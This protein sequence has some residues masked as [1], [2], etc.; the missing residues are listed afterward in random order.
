MLVRCGYSSFAPESISSP[1]KNCFFF[2]FVF[3]C[4]QI[5]KDFLI[6]AISDQKLTG[7]SVSYFWSSDRSAIHKMLALVMQ[8]RRNPRF[9]RLI[10]TKNE[11]RLWNLLASLIKTPK[12]WQYFCFLYR[13]PFRETRGAF[14]GTWGNWNI[15]DLIE[16][17][18]SLDA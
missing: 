5:T 11:T 3:V 7:E 18:V 2:S 14:D 1:G 13:Y 15:D 17:S 10:L 6:F 12:V 16:V 9:I 4:S 8:L